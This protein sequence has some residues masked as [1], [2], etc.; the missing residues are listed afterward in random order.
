MHL[1]G[2]LAGTASTE[3]ESPQIQSNQNNDLGLEIIAIS[4]S[5]SGPARAGKQVSVEGHSVWGK[6]YR[7]EEVNKLRLLYNWS[8]Y[9]FETL[10]FH[11]D[12][13]YATFFYSEENSTV[14][15]YPVFSNHWTIGGIS[16]LKSFSC[17]YKYFKKILLPPNPCCQF[18]GADWLCQVL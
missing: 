17:Y 16:F 3:P 7:P 6:R 12:I 13:L 18:L 9:C 1:S 8:T 15:I 11:S 10:F 4:W 14:T 2:S 5:H